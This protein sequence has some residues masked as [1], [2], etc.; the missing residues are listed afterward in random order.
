MKQILLLSLTIIIAT[1]LSAQNKQRQGLYTISDSIKA[2]GFI[3]DV[4]LRLGSWHTKR[5]LLLK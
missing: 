5:W 2:T 4:L 3:T 1:L